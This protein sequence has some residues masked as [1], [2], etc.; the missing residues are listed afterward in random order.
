MAP[1]YVTSSERL[2]RTEALLMIFPTTDP[3]LPPL[4]NCRVPALIVVLPL[5]VL[6]P[7]RMT[8]P[9]PSFVTAPEPEITPA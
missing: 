6:S 1:A 7:S 9:L 2:K 5:K 3:E 4:P 8:V